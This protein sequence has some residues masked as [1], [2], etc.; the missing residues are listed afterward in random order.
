MLTY[1]HVRHWKGFEL[2]STF[3]LYI[4][5]CS[6]F[7]LNFFHIKYYY[8]FIFRSNGWVQAYRK[9]LA[10]YRPVC[11]LTGQC[12]HTEIADTRS[13]KLN[14]WL[15][16]WTL[17][18]YLTKIRLLVWEITK[19]LTNQPTNTP[20][21]NTSWEGNYQIIWQLYLDLGLHILNSVARLNL[22]GDGLAG[23]RLNEDLHTTAQTEHQVKGRFFLDVVVAE[24][25]TIFQLLA[26]KDQ[27]LL[28]WRNALFVLK[29][30]IN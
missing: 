19:S 29:Y 4:S 14:I 28:I 25:T 24:G 30:N 15:R 12:W 21:S 17:V 11:S 16:L 27:T 22:E 8:K 2:G 9:S 26:G 5:K 18:S 1:C 13:Q 23:Q 6:T 3:Q 20:V 7:S 10:L